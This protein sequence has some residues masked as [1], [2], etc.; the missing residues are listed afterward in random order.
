MRRAQ[1]SVEFLFAMFIVVAITTI[2]GAAVGSELG[3]MNEMRDY[4]RLSDL[5]LSIK[6]EIDL[7]H[8]VKDGYQRE[9][10]VPYYLGNDNY[11]IALSSGLLM[12]SSNSQERVI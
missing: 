2:F 4:L 1:V 11:T 7:A 8:S 3:D 10:D 6:N 9:F 12:L 5:A